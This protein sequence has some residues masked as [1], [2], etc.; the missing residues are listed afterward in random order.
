MIIDAIHN[1]LN[2]GKWILQ[3]IFGFSDI[4]NHKAEKECVCFF[5]FNY[6]TLWKYKT[7]NIKTVNT[8]TFDCSVGDPETKKLEGDTLNRV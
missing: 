8:R 6:A 1:G 2:M 4:F 5:S 3:W 7:Q